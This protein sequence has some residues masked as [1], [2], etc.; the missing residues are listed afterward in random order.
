VSGCCK[1]KMLRK[2]FITNLLVLLLTSSL[3]IDNY[4]LYGAFDSSLTFGDSN[5]ISK[6]DYATDGRVSFCEREPCQYPNTL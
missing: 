2:I 6:K 4:A 5:N 3:A 1:N